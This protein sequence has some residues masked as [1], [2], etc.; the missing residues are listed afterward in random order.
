MLGITQK[1]VEVSI[2]EGARLDMAAASSQ[3]QAGTH[4]DSTLTEA[5]TYRVEQLTL[6]LQTAAN[7]VPVGGDDVEV[8]DVVHLRPV[9]PRRRADAAHAQRSAHGRIESMG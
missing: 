2:D 8:L 9:A 7:E 6:L 4:D 3:W 1:V 5:G